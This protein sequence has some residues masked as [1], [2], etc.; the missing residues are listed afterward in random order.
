MIGVSGRGAA[1]TVAG[2][3]GVVAAFV[4]LHKGLQA[5]GTNGA[6]CVAT[7]PCHHGLA[8]AMLL[9]PLGGLAC[10][11]VYSLSRPAAGPRLTLLAVP[12]LLLV[13]AWSWLTGTNRDTLIVA[14]GL[15][16]GA[17]GLGLL[18]PLSRP[19]YLRTIFWNDGRVPDQL[20]RT[21]GT[22][23]AT[24][25]TNDLTPAVVRRLRL[26]SSALHL[27][28]IVLGFS[29]GSVVAAAVLG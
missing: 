15:V 23:A 27:F 1:A 21:W 17:A 25:A 3:T 20:Y 10:L 8:T 19:R 5:I 14:L 2:L 16:F 11:L 4:L 7:Y 26:W 29:T 22:S 6:R 12:A 18:L 24:V 13:T 9:A 28:A